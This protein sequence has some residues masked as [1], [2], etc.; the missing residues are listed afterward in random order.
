[1]WC[2]LIAGVAADFAEAA[3]QAAFEPTAEIVVADLEASFSK[4]GPQF[5]THLEDQNSGY[6]A[7]T[8]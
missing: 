5:E 3:I 8:A 2:G 1:M 6:C 4:F 7:P